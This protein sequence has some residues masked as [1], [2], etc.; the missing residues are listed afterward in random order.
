MIRSNRLLA[1]A[2]LFALASAPAMA[3]DS[4]NAAQKEGYYASLKL[5]RG[6]LEAKNM[7]TSARPGI[8]AFVAGDNQERFTNGSIAGGYQFGN[9]WRVEGEYTAS[10]DA[11]FTSGSTRFPTSFNH[12]KV[13]A[14]RI[15]LNGY[16]DFALGNNFSLYATLGLGVARV[17]SDGWQGVNTR[18]Y[19]RNTDSNLT[20][21]AGVGAGYAINESWSLDLGY[22]YVDMG[23]IESGFNNFDNA[24]GLQDE[25]M[26][27]RLVSS[28]F[29]FGVRYTF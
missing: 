5:L 23:K 10:K 16:R 19:A 17:E 1:V 11:E 18:Q 9:G 6:E 15:M 8:G 29:L 20:Y 26:R 12:H 21:S 14:Q 22:R 2:G 4:S 28:E 27:A 7:A 25:Q 13:D 3:Q 24:R